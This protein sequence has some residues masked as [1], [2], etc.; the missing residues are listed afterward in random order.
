MRF[1]MLV[2]ICCAVM[3]GVPSSPAQAAVV[4]ELDITGG[5]INL[6]FGSLGTA[7]GNF[8]QNGTIVMGQ[9]QPL[10]NILSPVQVSH[11]TLSVFTNS[12]QPAVNLPAPSGS[13]SGNTMTLDLASLFGG[14]SSTQWGSW[15]TPATFGAVNIGGTA[16]GSFNE[17]TQAFDISWTHGF[18]GLPFLTGAT[19]SLR[20]T[21]QVTAVPLPA[22]AVLFTTGLA[23]LGVVASWRRREFSA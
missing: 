12:G 3:A 10:P 9:Y 15:M 22:A 16:T 6:N 4:T 11:L 7:G 5:S 19:F 14:L 2:L 17:T 21:A 13:T 8:V 1:H 23:G 18:T 20:G